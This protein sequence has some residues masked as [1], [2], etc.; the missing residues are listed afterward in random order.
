MQ[1]PPPQAAP[2]L[3]VEALGEISLPHLKGEGDRRSGGGVSF[4]IFVHV[5]FVQFLSKIVTKIITEIFFIIP[6]C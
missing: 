3:S 6:S 4:V 5:I 1:T 2:P